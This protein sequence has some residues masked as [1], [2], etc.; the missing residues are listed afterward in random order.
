MVALEKR[1]S[2]ATPR[3]KWQNKKQNFQSGDI[4]LLWDSDLMRNKWP[5]VKIVQTFKGDNGD[6]RSVHLKVGQSKSN[7]VYT[8]LEWPVTKIVLLLGQDEVRFPHKEH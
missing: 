6:V 4:V 1:V 7:E 3:K 8:I 5:M 2:S